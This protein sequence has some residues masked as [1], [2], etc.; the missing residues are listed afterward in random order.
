MLY[1]PKFLRLHPVGRLAWVGLLL[2]ARA[3]DPPGT[4]Q[5]TSREE[6]ANDLCGSL[7]IDDPY[8]NES[9]AAIVGRDIKDWEKHGMVTIADDGLVTIVNWYKRQGD[10]RPSGAPEQTRARKRLSRMSRDVTRGH[11]VSRDVTTEEKR[12]E[13]SRSEKRTTTPRPPAS[14]AGFDEFWTTY[15]RK[16]NKGDA[17][18]AWLALRPNEVLRRRILLAV[19]AHRACSDWQKEDGKYIPYPASWLRGERW[20]DTLESEIRPG[21]TLAQIL[22]EAP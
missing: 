11:A 17:R 3:G 14:D 22:G 20:E 18:K 19:A 7:R 4:W 10:L 1:D 16:A 6:V 15:P 13:E 9:W 12:R 21:R 5:A 8:L 2:M